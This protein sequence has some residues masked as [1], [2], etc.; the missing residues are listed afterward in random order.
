MVDVIHFMPKAELTAA[1][2]VAAFV[3]MTRERLTIFG[4]DLAFD[5]M[6]WDITETSQRRGLT[7]RHR[8]SFCTLPTLKAAVPEAMAEPFCTFAKACVRYLQGLRP[9][10]NPQFRLSALRAMEQ[11]LTENRLAGDPTRLNTHL[12]N[13]GA[14]IV[15]SHFGAA[16]AYRVGGQMEIIAD[17]LRD[18]RFTPVPLMWRNPIPRPRDTYRVGN[19]FEEERDQKMPSSA[20]LDA[21]AIAFRTATAPRDVIGISTTAL[22]CAAPDRIAEVLTLPVD[23]EVFHSR[24]GKDDAYGFRWWPAKGADPMVKWLV[25]SMAGVAQEALA[26]IRRLTDEARRISAW[27]EAN[28]GCLYLPEELQYLREADIISFEDASA[29]L[30]QEGVKGWA[31]RKGIAVPSKRGAHGI[32]FV[33][34]ERAVLAMLPHGFPIFDHTTGLKFSKALFVV[35]LNLF[36]PDCAPSRCMIMPVNQQRIGDSLGGRIRHGSSSVFSRLGLTEPDGSPIEINSHQFRHWLNTLA[37]RGGLSQLDIA[38]WSGRKDVSQNRVYDHM[39]GGEI[40]GLVRDSVANDDQLFGAIVEFRPNAPVSRDEFARMLVPTAH[41]TEV[42]FCVH[43]FAALPCQLHRD[44]VN[45]PEQVCIKGD[46]AKTARLRQRLAADRQLLMKAE[47]AAAKRIHGADRWLVHHRT[48]VQRLEQLLALMED[49]SIPD[50]TVIRLAPA[51]DHSFLL[52]PERRIIAVE[53]VETATSP[54]VEEKLSLED[55]R[56]AMGGMG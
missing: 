28:P 55:L 4:A 7:H 10:K 14:Q 15:K 26:K 13:R 3:A 46:T 39:S 33:R 45:C 18:K 5:E 9:T 48:T 54:G 2:N 41:S 30:G 1:E 47:S 56:A 24:P 23:C 40:L 42:G 20:A 11:A 22:M 16:A 19:E 27:Y 50:G 51:P 6:V 17:L 53:T 49:A 43:D 21:V 37:Q 35:P 36:R 8:M 25:P 52:Q 31:R 44:C 38:K 32:D 12:L 29:L 34:F